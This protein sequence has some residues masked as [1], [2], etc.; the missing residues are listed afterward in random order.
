MGLAS[1][2]NPVYSRYVS[3]FFAGPLSPDTVI[4]NSGLH[5]GLHHANIQSF[6]KTV[7]MAMEY[8]HDIF[9][10]VTSEKA[11]QLVYRTTVAP[12]GSARGSQSNPQKMEVY[13]RIMTEQVQKW[14][15]EVK[16]VDEFDMSFPFHYDNRYSD[17]G[18]Y[19]RPPDPWHVHF[20][21][22]DVMLAHVLLN[23]ICPRT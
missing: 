14:F 10:N 12:A 21:F 5:D 2:E 20:Y 7:D 13:N 17:G 19:G 8:W 18:H 3:R 16:I 22:V 23:A 1:L 11:P 4:M 15:T 6:T 9:S